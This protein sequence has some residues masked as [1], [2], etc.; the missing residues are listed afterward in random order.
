MCHCAYRISS[1]RRHSYYFFLLLV[2]CGYYSRVVFISLETCR[3]Q[4]RVEKVRTS[5][6]VMVAK[7]CQYYAQCLSPAVSRGNDSYKT[8][9][10][11]VIIVRNH[12]HIPGLLAA[13]T[14][15]GPCLFCSEL[16]IVRL[17]FE[18]GDYSK[19]ASI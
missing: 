5:E 6:T 3:Y 16:R 12:L 7:R 13:G 18:G 15:R 17:L 9:S 14:I 11:V 1:I 10:C 4:Q 8:N 19:V 2:L